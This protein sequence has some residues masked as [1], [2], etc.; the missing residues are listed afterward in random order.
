MLIIVDASQSW[1]TRAAAA[2]NLS[3]IPLES[4]QGALNL[5]LVCIELVRLAK[6]MG[7][8]NALEPDL[9]HWKDTFIRLYLAFNP[10]EARKAKGEGLLEQIARRPALGKYAQIATESYQQILPLV[11]KVALGS[12]KVD[13]D[14]QIEQ[15]EKWLEE[16]PQKTDRISPNEDPIVTAV[17]P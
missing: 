13:F 2:Y 12:E 3:R 14:K 16:H 6:E 4:S 7:D 10:G 1:R 15:M 17:K 8:A 9:P 5:E 11:N